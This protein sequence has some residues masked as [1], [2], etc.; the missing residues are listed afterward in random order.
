MKQCHECEASIKPGQRTCPK[1]GT[2]QRPGGP[3]KPA[4]YSG[5]KPEFKD[6]LH[7]CCEWVSDGRC[8]Y[9]GVFKHGGRWLCRQHDGCDDPITG[10]Q[11]VEQSHRDIPHPDYSHAAIKARSLAE[12]QRQAAE[13]SAIG[14]VKKAA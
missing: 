4:R 7:G 6:P 1:C 11:I 14:K 3:D 8:H 5:A 9:P 13:F 10:A 12:V 2:I